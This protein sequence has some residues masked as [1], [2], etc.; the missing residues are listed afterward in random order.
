[1][2]RRIAVLR[3]EPGNRATASAIEARGYDAI[4][5]PLFEVRALAWDAPDAGAF[6][7]LI[8]TSANAIRHGG[9]GL[10]ALL[11]LPVYAVG[12]ATAEAARGAGF[13]VACVGTEDAE[14][15]VAAAETAGIRRALHLAGRER[16]LEAGGIVARVIPVYAS[17]PEAPQDVARLAGSI[18]L[19][20]SARAGARLGHIVD[21]A[22][23][24][25]DGIL[26]V[27]V[28][29]RAAEAAGQGWERVVVP[30]DLRSGALIEAA[31][32][33]AD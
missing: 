17:E 25:R 6:D 1:M 24:D 20:Q 2:S 19:V 15:L 27:A 21:A 23:I 31:I 18:A 12:T 10:S 30:D 5:I 28:S 22:R 8:L 32:A 4:R 3:P 26:L 13:R 11:R 16:T 14:A 33:L 9:P 29:A 7:A